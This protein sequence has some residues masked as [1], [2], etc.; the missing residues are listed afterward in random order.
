MA[1]GNRLG[2][3]LLRGAE[4]M[5]IILRECAHP[6]HAV[7][8]ARRFVAMAFA[9]LAQPHRQLAI[10]GN[11]LLENLHVAR[12]IHRLDGIFAP[13]RRLGAEHVFA[14]RFEMPGL[15]PQRR[16]DNFRRVDFTIAGVSVALPHVRKQR[17]KQRP[18]VGVPE[19]RA[20]R[21]L[22]KME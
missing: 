4:Y 14:E 10:T 16:A 1:D 20:R 7:Q 15:F 8:R 17:L 21:F 5:R 3:D 19:H 11:A 18:A 13:V 12:A 22:L 2:A 6:H 9:E